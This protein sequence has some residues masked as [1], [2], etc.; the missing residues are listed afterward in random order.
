[1]NVMLSE[2]RGVRSRKPRRCCLCGEGIG[3]GEAHDTRTGVDYGDMWTMR[4]H[5]ECHAYE[6]KRGAVDPD[7]YED[8]S[9]PAFNRADAIAAMANE[10]ACNVGQRRTDARP[11]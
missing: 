7:W 1:M 4:M 9:E 8:V 10:S 3:I 6:G 5:P 11:H 2:A